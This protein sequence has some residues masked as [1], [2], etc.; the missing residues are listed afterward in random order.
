MY[1]EVT[2]DMYTVMIFSL[3][4]INY[5]LICRCLDACKAWGWDTKCFNFRSQ[6]QIQLESQVILTKLVIVVSF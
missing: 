2:I 4:W 5:I 1:A 6:F 3:S